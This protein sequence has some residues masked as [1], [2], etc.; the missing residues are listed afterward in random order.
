MNRISLVVSILLLFGYLQ[1]S[2]AQKI[3]NLGEKACPMWIHHLDNYKNP[4][5]E[6]WLQTLD[7]WA[8]GFVKGMAQQYA[9]S[10]REKNPL[11]YLR[12]KEPIEWMQAYC[13]VNKDK[14]MSEAALAMLEELQDRAFRDANK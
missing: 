12:E 5:H 6:Q 3:P 11:L 13:R 10:S 4:F 8:M 7:W 1:P 2:Y 9:F 14:S